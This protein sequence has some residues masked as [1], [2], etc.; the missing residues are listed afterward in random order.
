VIEREPVVL[1][2]QVH[3]LVFFD[4]AALVELPRDL[5]LQGHTLADGTLVHYVRWN[6]A[7]VAELSWLSLKIQ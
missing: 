1:G 4:D 5:P 3:V 7:K 6:E 2:E